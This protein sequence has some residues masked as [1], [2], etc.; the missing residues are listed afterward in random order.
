MADEKK[1]E[2]AVDLKEI[3]K[4]VKAEEKKEA[5]VE[6]KEAPK[7]EKKKKKEEKVDIV[8]ENVYIIPLRS[9]YLSKPHYRRTNKAVRAVK[10]YLKRHTKSENVVLDAGLNNHM[11]ARG[12]S[13]PPR[14]VQVKAVKDS[15]GKVVA[16]LL[17]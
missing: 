8:S 9:A 13:K 10:D 3:E 1:K 11:W 7:E 15:E 6:K 17:K 16:S 2:D 5:K 14:K 4:E 12:A